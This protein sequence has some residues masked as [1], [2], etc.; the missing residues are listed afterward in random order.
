MASRG[1]AEMARSTC[2]SGSWPRESCSATSSGTFT[3]ATLPVAPR[4]T[5]GLP[6][7]GQARGGAAAARFGTGTSGYETEQLVLYRDYV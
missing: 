2:R 7:F 3:A 5:R 4:Q 6:S 1:A